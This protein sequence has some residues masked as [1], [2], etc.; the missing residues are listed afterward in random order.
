MHCGVRKSFSIRS[1]TKYKMV[2]L[3][4]EEKIRNIL[5]EK[6]TICFY[7]VMNKPKK[8]REHNSFYV[9]SQGRPLHK[10]EKRLLRTSR[11]REF[12]N[13]CLKVLYHQ[14]SRST[15][16]VKGHSQLLRDTPASRDQKISKG[17]IV[18]QFLVDLDFWPWPWCMQKG[19]Q[20]LLSLEQMHLLVKLTKSAMI[21]NV[22]MSQFLSSS[23]N[24]LLRARVNSNETWGVF[25]TQG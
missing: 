19:K 1:Q 3:L 16:N 24:T 5:T 25:K 21:Y 7:T 8:T 18:F 9:V 22:Q 10:I 15:V 2:T 12:R 23:N 14:L 4:T 13:L 17:D 20:N 6:S 11:T